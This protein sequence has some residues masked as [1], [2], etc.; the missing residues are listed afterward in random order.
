MRR[1]RGLYVEDDELTVKVVQ[2]SFRSSAF[3]QGAANRETYLNLIKTS[4]I[5][6]L[7][8]DG[9]IAGWPLAEYA[10]DVA[11]TTK[12]PI[13]I[14][15]ASPAKNL[16]PLMALGPKAFVRKTDGV[17]VLTDAVLSYFYALEEFMFAQNLPKPSVLS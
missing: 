15:S 16:A 12:L 10:K 1:L 4:A 6:F 9:E 17:Q 2:R 5:D 14:F 7:I 13:F 3:I 8:L 11:A